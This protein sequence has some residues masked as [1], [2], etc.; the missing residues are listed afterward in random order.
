MFSFSRRVGDPDRDRVYPPVYSA[1]EKSFVV[2]SVKGPVNPL[3]PE[4][5]IVVARGASSLPFD[6]LRALDTDLGS[7]AGQRVID[8]LKA[9]VADA[10]QPIAG[11]IDRGLVVGLYSDSRISGP[12]TVRT[13]L[14]EM[15]ADIRFQISSDLLD[16][17]GFR[18]A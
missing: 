11:P 2:R 8:T 17:G 15:R 7:A 6:V 14:A 1:A 13:I 5:N 10:G 16:V 12:G 18:S 4:R 3:D 9:L